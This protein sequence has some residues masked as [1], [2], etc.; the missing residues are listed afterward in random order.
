MLN[1]GAV[2][3]ARRQFSQA[4][5]LIRHA[6]LM[7]SVTGDKKAPYWLRT[8]GIWSRLMEV[9]AHPRAAEVAME[10]TCDLLENSVGLRHPR[11]GMA[12][13]NLSRLYDLNGK[14]SAALEAVSQALTIFRAHPDLLI[15][16][17]TD[18]EERQGFLKLQLEGP[19][20]AFPT[21]ALPPTEILQAAVLQFQGRPHRALKATQEAYKVFLSKVGPDH[22]RATLYW[23]LM[24]AC[25][26]DLGHLR[27][28]ANFA[29]RVHKRMKQRYSDKAPE[30]FASRVQQIEIVMDLGEP[31][32]AKRLLDPLLG[33]LQRLD[34]KLYPRKSG[35]HPF[36]AQLLLQKARLVSLY[37]DFT[38]ALRFLVRARIQTEQGFGSMSLRLIPLLLQEA[39][40]LVELNRLQDT[41]T[42]LTRLNSLLELHVSPSRNLQRDLLA[43]TLRIRQSPSEVHETS[44]QSMVESVGRKL[45]ATHPLS[46]E[47]LSIQAR[48]QE[49]QGRAEKAQAL[50]LQVITGAEETFAPGAP[51][52]LS[53]QLSLAQLFLSKGQRAQAQT[54]LKKAVFV[55]QERLGDKFLLTRKLTKAL[56][57]CQA[58]TSP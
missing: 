57:R 19:A 11:M 40:T 4:S 5:N 2:A 30:S 17:Q 39:H 54:I 58:S 42:V 51:T 50:W 38:E 28:A 46:L 35:H 47:A 24:A 44:L 14:W 48:S 33:S 12:L 18:V 56:A 16:R 23:S 43:L 55:A 26:R 13:L 8:E 29:R 45:G 41:Q 27:L 22:L 21:Q 25:H 15:R 34:G 52:T 32:K 53:A 37:G 36:R 31:K 3:L 49:A 9:E 6:H 10:E 7:Q 1:M 20:L